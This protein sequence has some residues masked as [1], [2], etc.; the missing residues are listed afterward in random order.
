MLS[1]TSPATPTL[2]SPHATN[3]APDGRAYPFGRIV[4]T[5][6]VGPYIITTIERTGD[7][8]EVETSYSGYLQS[9]AILAAHWKPAEDVIVSTNRLHETLDEAL[10]FLISYRHVGPN[11]AGPIASHFFKGLAS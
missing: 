5:Q 6:Q 7:T 9:A 3:I 1:S 11:E 2:P 4:E 10:A 8:G